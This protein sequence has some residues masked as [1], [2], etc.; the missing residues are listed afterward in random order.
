VNFDA[1][2]RLA[3]GADLELAD[4]INATVGGAIAW[5]I[6]VLA[7]VAAAGG[8]LAS[9]AMRRQI[10]AI[11]GTADAIISGDLAQRVPLRG[12]GDDFDRLAAALNRMLDRIG[13]LMESLRQMSNDVAHSLRSPLTR[14][15][16]R[17]ES[18]R[19]ESASPE[20]WRAHSGAAIAELDT[21]LET[22]SA[23]LRI[24]QVGSG[25]ERAGFREVD[26]TEVF[27]TICEA[28]TPA[29]EDEG[30]T[31]VAEI[32]PNV[33]T[34]GDKDLLTQML[35]NVVENALLYTPRGTR[36]VVRLC[37]V[38]PVA[39]VSDNGPGVST[40]ERDRIF[41]RFYRAARDPGVPGVGLGLAL[42]SAIANLHGIAV[43]A[44]GNGPGLR[45][46]MRFGVANTARG[47]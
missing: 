7:G 1:S 11:T 31:L 17:L 33:V 8:A 21:I 16:Q 5:W 32:A 4:E 29:A 45:I 27:L 19:D 23:L 2:A 41:D 6:L 24:A 46:V 36:I 40:A 20:E 30:K 25:T 38:G 39:T 42:V 9:R 34:F 15:R 22:F 28:F 14:L 12:T 18:V 10:N 13:E 44:E 35:A 26:L 47:S 3:V 37:S 43:A